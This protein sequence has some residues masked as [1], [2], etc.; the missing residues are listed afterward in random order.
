M[1]SGDVAALVDERTE[2]KLAGAIDVVEADQAGA[3]DHQQA[4]N[5]GS[6][7]ENAHLFVVA[8]PSPRWRGKTRNI[9]FEACLITSQLENERPHSKIELMDCGLF[10]AEFAEPSRAAVK[11]SMTMIQFKLRLVCI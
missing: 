11:Q 6:W 8:A 5:Q 10:E 9:C 7:D 1:P 2:L 4:Q 3:E